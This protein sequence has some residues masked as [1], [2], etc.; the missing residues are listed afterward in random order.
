MNQEA[1]FWERIADMPAAEAE[2]ELVARRLAL[3]AENLALADLHRSPGDS[4]GRRM[5][6][7]STAL[8]VLN[9]RI[10][11]LRKLRTAISWRAAVDAVYGADGVERCV[12]WIEQQM[13]LQDTERQGWRPDAGA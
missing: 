3:V 1:V 7:N 13:L 11:Y 2:Q 4:A 12:I 6:E 10:K 8:A 5:I 9:E